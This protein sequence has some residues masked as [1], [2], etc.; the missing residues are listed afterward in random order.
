MSRAVLLP[1]EEYQKARITF[2]QSIAELATRHQN[3]N[4]EAVKAN[5]RKHNPGSPFLIGESQ[6]EDEI[7]QADQKSWI[8]N[9]LRFD[10]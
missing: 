1:F 6:P 3:T 9:Q 7:H 4:T 2:V 5:M 8:D 10:I